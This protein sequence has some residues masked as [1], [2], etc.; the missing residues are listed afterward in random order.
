[1]KY[2]DNAYDD[3]AYKRQFITIT[4]AYK[5]QFITITDAEL[6]SFAFSNG[7]EDKI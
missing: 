4:D 5:W 2:D 3:N 6:S 1:M 7:K